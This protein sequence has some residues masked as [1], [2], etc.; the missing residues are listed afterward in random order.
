MLFCMVFCTLISDFHEDAVTVILKMTQWD[1]LVMPYSMV[2]DDLTLHSD[3]SLCMNS[4]VVM[5]TQ[6]QVL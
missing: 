1:L 2:E 5:E 6:V 3:C 4:Y